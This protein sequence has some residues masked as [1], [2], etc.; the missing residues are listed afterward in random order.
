MAICII[1]GTILDGSENPISNTL[2]TAFPVEAPT[3][4]YQLG[5]IIGNSFVQTVTS[6]TGYF[7]L[8]LTQGIKFCITIRSI[9]YKEVLNVPSQDTFDLWSSQTS[10]GTTSTGD[11]STGALPDP[12]PYPRAPYIQPELIPPTIGPAGVPPMPPVP[13]ISTPNPSSNEW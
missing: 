12:L 10:T 4:D 1:T 6:S 5:A 7:A 9:G 13:P 2:V 3:N 8:R 11:T